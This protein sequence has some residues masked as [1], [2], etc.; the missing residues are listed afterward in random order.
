MYV[1][2]TNSC[3]SSFGYFIIKCLDKEM[4]D[5]NRIQNEICAYR[6]EKHNQTFYS[7]KING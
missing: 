4:F 5:F 1:E 6:L 3:L 2:L 7:L